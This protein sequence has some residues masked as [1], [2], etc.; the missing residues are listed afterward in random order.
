MAQT[1]RPA[2]FGPVF[3]VADFHTFLCRVRCKINL[4]IFVSN[5]QNIEKKKKHLLNGPNDA[6]RVV[7]A[8]HRHPPLSLLCIHPLQVSCLAL[9]RILYNTTYIY[10]KT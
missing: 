2:S 5:K 10:N 3:V 9:S 1:T 8:S 4:Y 6:R 7:W